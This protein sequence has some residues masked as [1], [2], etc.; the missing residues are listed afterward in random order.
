MTTN[1][2]VE[3]FYWLLCFSDFVNLFI[4]V[5]YCD[6]LFFGATLLDLYFTVLCVLLA[7]SVIHIWVKEFSQSILRIGDP[8]CAKCTFSE[9]CHPHIEIACGNYTCDDYR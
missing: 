3:S 2:N 5:T 6:F 9:V 4:F 7:I 8:H 1:T